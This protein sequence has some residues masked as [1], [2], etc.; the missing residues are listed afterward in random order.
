M[1]DQEF[2]KQVHQKMEEIKILPSDAV[3]KEVEKRLHPRN[4]SRRWIWI[5]IFLFGIGIGGY[6]MYS[7]NPAFHQSLQPGSDVL[8]HNGNILKDNKDKTEHIEEVSKTTTYKKQDTIEIAKLSTANKERYLSGKGNK[9]ALSLQLT[10]PAPATH[11]GSHANKTAKPEINSLLQNNSMNSK[12]R[13][14][15]VENSSV[16]TQHLHNTESLSSELSGRRTDDSSGNM[17]I[18]KEP[19]AAR[20]NLSIAPSYPVNTTLV[21]RN[22]RV[23]INAPAQK[24]QKKSGWEWGVSVRAGQS[25]VTNGNFSNLFTNGVVADMFNSP[26]LG[27]FS[28]NP[29]AIYVPP[30]VLK[31]G[32]GLS[33]GVLIIKQ[34]TRRTSLS[35]GLHYTRFSTSHKVGKRITDSIVTLRNNSADQKS[36]EDYFRLGNTDSY[37]NKYHFIELPVLFETRLTGYRFVPVYWDLGVSFSRLISSNALHYDGNSKIYYKNNSLFNRN[38]F[39]IISGLPIGILLE[40]RV[41]LKTGPV[42]QYN[43]SNLINKAQSGGR[44]LLFI[45]VK[46]DIILFK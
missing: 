15:L 41:T 33:A 17:S 30:S 40:E 19:V 20:V 13:D 8:L 29:S 26:N 9:P 16:T 22:V 21:L 35:A 14:D 2:E 4:K 44:H 46:A 11:S 43:I 24:Q 27:N 31:P 7:N 6:L 37:Q 42:F 32:L 10:L 25:G 39:S 1:Q 23:A 36:I 38:Q 28:V 45:G 18:T 34:L 12:T 3:W 5:P